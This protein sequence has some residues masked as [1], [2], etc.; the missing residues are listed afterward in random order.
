MDA[1]T[2]ADRSVPFAVESAYRLQ[3]TW[4][5]RLRLR[6]DPP[7][8]VIYEI[9]TG[10]PRALQTRFRPWQR[11]P[12][13]QL[14]THDVVTQPG[15]GWIEPATPLA[16]LGS[17]F[18]RGI[19]LRLERAQHH[20]VVVEE[21]PGADQ[22]GVRVGRIFHTASYR[23]TAA[24][25]IDEFHPTQPWWEIPPIIR[26]PYRQGIAWTDHHSATSELKMH[27]S[28]LQ[29]LFVQAEVCICSMESSEVWR[30]RGDHAAFHT[31]P[32][33]PVFDTQR[34]EFRVLSVDENVAN[35]LYFIDVVRG[36][37]RD[38]KFV[39]MV[40]PIPIP[41]TFQPGIGAVEADLLSKSM[42]R[43][44]VHEVCAQRPGVQYFPAYEMIRRIDAHPWNADFRH[45]DGLAFDRLVASL[46]RRFGP[47]DPTPNAI[48]SS[49]MRRRRP[50]PEVSPAAT[51]T[52]GVAE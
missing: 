8:D 2:P 4:A 11:H 33:D 6:D 3:T 31:I 21:G 38:M 50:A 35:L 30:T 15:L 23:Q 43:A 52:V 49:H 19:R 37:N 46:L 7:I 32:P 41:M 29:A 14:R 24:R 13:D 26:D 42:L 45:V 12:G 40:S 1:E 18:M 48:R 27:A 10:L 47:A 34:H 20:C 25:A 39:L 5:R 36:L 16:T 44:A 22:S 28:A 17:C 9:E 51:A